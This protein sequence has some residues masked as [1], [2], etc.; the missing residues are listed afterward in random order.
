[1]PLAGIIFI[2]CLQALGFWPKMR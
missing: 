2:Q 1:M